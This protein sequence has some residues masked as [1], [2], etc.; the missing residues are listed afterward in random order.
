MPHGWL[1]KVGD[2]DARIKKLRLA[3]ALGRPLHLGR[4][5]T[6]R[7]VTVNG[8]PTYFKL[9]RNLLSSGQAVSF[10]M[11]YMSVF[12]GF[13]ESRYRVYACMQ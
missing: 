12:L 10:E 2:L 13:G 4:R 5:G 8:P 7:K 1:C 3:E 11:S 9:Q 6:A